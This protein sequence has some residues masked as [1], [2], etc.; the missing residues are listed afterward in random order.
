MEVA[1]LF[2]MH[3]V[4]WLVEVQHR[5]DEA[6]LAMVAADTARRLDVFRCRLGLPLDQHETETRDVETDRYHVGGERHI[7]GVAVSAEGRFE[8]LLRGRHGVGRNALGQL[9]RLSDLTIAE[10]CA[11]G[12]EALALGAVGPDTSTH[13]V[14]DDPP[15]AA[16]L[17]QRV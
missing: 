15:S 11:D 12:R 4:A 8:T 1:E 6:W 5:H 3:A 9:H 14:L 13:L 16:E 10:G 2:I 17:P 7:D